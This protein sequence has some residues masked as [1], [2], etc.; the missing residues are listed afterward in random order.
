[1]MDDKLQPIGHGIVRM[2]LQI[3]VKHLVNILHLKNGKT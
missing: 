3:K 1:M 2:T